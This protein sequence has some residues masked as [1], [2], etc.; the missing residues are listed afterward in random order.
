[1]ETRALR[2][3]RARG[4]GGRG[5]EVLT[6]A[7]GYNFPLFLVY[8]VDMPGL[9]VTAP[10]TC[11]S[12]SVPGINWHIARMLSSQPTNSAGWPTENESHRDGSVVCVYLSVYFSLCTW[13]CNLI[14][15]WWQT[16]EMSYGDD[17]V[18]CVSTYLV[19]LPVYCSLFVCVFVCNTSQRTG[20]ESQ[21]DSVLFVSVYLS[22]CL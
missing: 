6:W 8:P 1:M 19:S 5:E 2:N 10:Y 20:D 21:R 16:A 17:S 15:M 14:C 3:A 9:S 7:S 12:R 22:V 11:L 4:W 18:L 13:L